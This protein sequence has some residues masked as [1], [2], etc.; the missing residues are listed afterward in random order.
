MAKAFIPQIAT[1]NDLLEGDVVYLT[2]EGGWSR[3]LGDAA[4]ATSMK[5]AAD[6]LERAEGFPNQVVGAYL[7]DVSLDAAGR[8]GPSHFREEFRLR[9]PSNRPEHGRARAALV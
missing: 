5:D 8:P 7:A 9:G 6:L 1:G 3:A 2:L 4:V